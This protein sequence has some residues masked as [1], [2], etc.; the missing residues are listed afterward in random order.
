MRLL[1]ACH[2]MQEALSKFLLKCKFLERVYAHLYA[3]DANDYAYQENEVLIELALN[4]N[5]N[6]RKAIK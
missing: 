4:I 5:K 6:G 3:M 2:S 1:P